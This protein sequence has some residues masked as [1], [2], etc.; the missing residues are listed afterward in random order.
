MTIEPSVDDLKAQIATL[1]DM[2]RALENQRNAAQNECVQLA[3]AYHAEVRKGAALQTRV[4][5]LTEA[6][7][8]SG[9]GQEGPTQ[10][11]AA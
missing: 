4:H 7:G 8:R 9:D 1:Q 11:Q 10:R 5:E 6:T 2:M 3:G